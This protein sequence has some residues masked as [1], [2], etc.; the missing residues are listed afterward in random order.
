MAGSIAATPTMGALRRARS[1]AYKQKTITTTPEPTASPVVVVVDSSL[2]ERDAKAALPKY[3]AAPSRKQLAVLACKFASHSG[4]VTGYA[5]VKY[6]EHLVSTT[7]EAKRAGIFVSTMRDLE[8]RVDIDEVREWL[9]KKTI[10]AVPRQLPRSEVEMKPQRSYR[11]YST[12]E[13]RSE[14]AATT[15]RSLREMIGRI[16][17]KRGVKP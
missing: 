3:V 6:V 14:L 10:A 13:L 9:A 5:V 12:E 11:D 7:P 16:L 1:E 4:E 15:S 2:D 8:G 17:V